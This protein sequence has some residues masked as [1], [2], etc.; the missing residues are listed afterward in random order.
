MED[1]G[2]VEVW[3]ARSNAQ[4]H[5]LKA[6]LEDEGIDAVVAS[7]GT[8]AVF[9]GVQLGGSEGPRLY[10]RPE[11]SERALVLLREHE[12]ADAHAGDDDESPSS[13]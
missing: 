9:G 5:I 6:R 10:V 2:L 1:Q 13:P 3:R 8:Q 4:A 11:D 7:G 12:D